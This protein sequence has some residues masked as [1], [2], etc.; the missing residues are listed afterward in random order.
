M[1]T[2]PKE[3]ID[4]TLRRAEVMLHT[5]QRSTENVNAIIDYSRRCLADSR[6]A[7]AWASR[8]PRPELATP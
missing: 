2:S 8:T 1:K 4:D 6:A 5:L 3:S 7:V